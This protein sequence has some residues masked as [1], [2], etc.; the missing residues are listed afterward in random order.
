MKKWLAI[1][2]VHLVSPAAVYAQQDLVLALARAEEQL[3]APTFLYDGDEWTSLRF[4]GLTREERG[5][6]LEALSS[7]LPRTWYLPGPSSRF[8]EVRVGPANGFPG[9]PLEAWP[10]GLHDVEGVGVVFDRPG[11]RGS[12]FY[13]TREDVIK[14]N[15]VLSL[16]EPVFD[17]AEISWVRALPEGVSSRIPV[18][19]TDRQSQ[20]IVFTTLLQAG[21]YVWFEAERAYVRPAN[22]RDSQCWDVSV[23]EGWVLVEPPDPAAPEV[24]GGPAE[25]QADRLNESFRVTDCDDKGQGYF[26]PYST[27]SLDEREWVIVMH[28]EYDA[29]H[30][31]LEPIIYERVGQEFR[32][33]ARVSP[34]W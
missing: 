5:D 26:R 15:R 10:E 32:E 16:V 2:L 6:S 13:D 3:V 31:G 8:A 27:F 19:I 4:Q 29:M 7:R 33:S 30:E 23:L 20:S 21:R 22:H 18:D 24:L 28:A 1:A 14:W 12:A 25:F 11:I 34:Y 17:S 9:Q